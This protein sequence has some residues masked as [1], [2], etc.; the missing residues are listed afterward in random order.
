M[1]AQEIM[2]K[3]YLI[4]NGVA[5]E[6]PTTLAQGETPYI[7]VEGDTFRFRQYG[8]GCGVPFITCPEITTFLPEGVVVCKKCIDLCK[9]CADLCE[10][11]RN[12]ELVQ[13]ALG[14][15]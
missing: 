5:H 12:E 8:P 11:R 10:A 1:T 4:Y 9:K 15:K 7:V 14:L 13:R 6:V 3:L 2:K